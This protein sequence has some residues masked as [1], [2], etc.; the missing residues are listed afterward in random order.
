MKKLTL[1]LLILS[2]DP[3]LAATFCAK[4]SAQFQ[5]AL[6]QAN[7]NGE[8]DE[9]RIQIGDH[10]TPG[11]NQFNFLNSESQDL[12]ISGGWIS[13]GN[14]DCA[15]QSGYPQLTRLDGDG[16]SP[17]LWYVSDG[18]D[19]NLTVSNLSIVNGFTTLAGLNSG[20]G[21][22]IS[23]TQSSSALIDRV[24]FADNQSPA[25]SAFRLAGGDL[26]TIRNSVFA[27]N[28]ADDGFG[29]LSINML[30]NAEGLYFINNTLVD[31]QTNSTWTGTN[32]TA[33]LSLSMAESMQN[34]PQTL[35]ANNLFWGNE[36]SDLFVSGAGG[37][38]YL[39]HNNYE[40]VG[41]TFADQANNL[42]LPPL[43][44]TDPLNF[45][46]T[47]QSPLIDTGYGPFVPIVTLP[48]E[49]NWYV[50]EADFDDGSPFAQANGRL[51]GLGL[52]IGAVEAP[53]TPIFKTG[54]EQLQ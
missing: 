40:L 2:Y 17:V 23:N 41:G 11:E 28:I 52:D 32:N 16:S 7:A 37:M 53:E 38:A 19:G 27:N 43:L 13:I 46:P 14:I 10:S 29:T 34:I 36:N 33:G 24:Y 3:L 51:I 49:Q 21:L 5:A 48:F 12:V 31:N 35:I 39:Y 20:L 9:I 15:V 44:S 42:S 18:F 22:Y 30:E 1:L 25:G 6:N 8:N 26:L 4:T 50:G 45:T 47:A 54:F